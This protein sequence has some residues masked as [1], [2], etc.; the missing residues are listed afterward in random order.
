MQDY[1]RQF[2]EDVVA[3]LQRRGLGFA[4][5]PVVCYQEVVKGS[6]SSQAEGVVFLANATIILEIEKKSFPADSMVKYHRALS[7]GLLRPPIRG[8]RLVIVQAFIT[9]GIRPLRVD[10]A[11]HVGNLLERDFGVR[12]V[13][14]EASDSNISALTK[15]LEDP[16]LCALS[17]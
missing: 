9:K 13:S 10:N 17:N 5:P 16:L 11:K 14:V 8:N 3:L 2:V 7:L 4:E 6:S 1:E 15:A 12:Y